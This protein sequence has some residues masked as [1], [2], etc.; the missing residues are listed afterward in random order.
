MNLQS[1]TGRLREVIM[2]YK[3]VGQRTSVPYL[4][5]DAGI[6]IYSVEELCYYIRENI[7]MLDRDF[8]TM[9][10]LNF[11]RDELSLSELSEKLFHVVQYNGTFSDLVETLFA[12]VSFVSNSEL[13]TINR[14]LS[15]SDRLSAHEKQ[16]IR[17]DFLM[18]CGRSALAAIAY[19]D[20]LD[21]M[22]EEKTP[23]EAARIH[24]N[25]G[26]AW[27]VQFLFDGAAEHFE[28]AYQ[29]NPENRENLI[30]LIIAK[31]LSLSEE[32]YKD[33]V[34]T[35]EVDADILKEAEE[36][37][38]AAKVKKLKRLDYRALKSAQRLKD[39]GDVAAFWEK[40][41]LVLSDMKNAYRGSGIT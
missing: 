2:V 21:C 37:F 10:L 26:V 19:M 27:S 12:G 25:I 35:H 6:G 29:L 9:E 11:I 23:K 41:A 3:C 24:H 5:K 38:E 28:K 36:K 33:Y 17:G 14:A 8:F 16:R 1:D 32:E 18:K 13:G 7:F 31:K 40:A 15:V 22:D 4:I 34:S 39:S 30:A 20:A